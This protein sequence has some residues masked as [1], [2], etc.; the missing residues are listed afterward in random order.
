MPKIIKRTRKQRLADRAAKAHARA[1]ERRAIPVGT[2]RVLN[3]SSP[4]DLGG[5]TS[6]V[7]VYKREQTLLDK[8]NRKRC[9]DR[10]GRRHWSCK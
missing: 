2:R 5:G 1:L 8:Q 7:P 6:N 4:R 10:Q 3:Y 9:R